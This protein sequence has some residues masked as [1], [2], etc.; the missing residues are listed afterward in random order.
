ML[1]NT[2]M[3]L[4]GVMHVEAHLLDC[5]GDVRPGEG[6]VLGEFRLGYGRQSGH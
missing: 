4:T 6:E 3:G 5:I 1:H 2:K